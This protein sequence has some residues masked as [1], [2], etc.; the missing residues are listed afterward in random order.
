MNWDVH[1]VEQ[2]D[3]GYW[4]RLFI[5]FRIPTDCIQKSFVLSARTKQ[6]RELLNGFLKTEKSCWAAHVCLTS[7]NNN[8][9][10]A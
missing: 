2:L 6:L 3:S 10:F 4:V 5:R 8:S 1:S 9:N 7:D